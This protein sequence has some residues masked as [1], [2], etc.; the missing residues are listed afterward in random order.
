M[1]E[2]KSTVKVDKAIEKLN[3][4]VIELGEV[5]RTVNEDEDNFN[6][7]I[8]ITY[9]DVKE[10]KD[11][12]VPMLNDYRHWLQEYEDGNIQLNKSVYMKGENAPAYKKT[13]DEELIYKLWKMRKSIREIARQVG[14][15]PDTVKRR[16]AK[17]QH[18]EEKR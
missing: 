2:E 16:I 9:E 14:C 10:L 11:E 18:R 13:I 17:M 4:I 7:F 12:I 15:S 3:T 6:P 1:K 8:A 5:F